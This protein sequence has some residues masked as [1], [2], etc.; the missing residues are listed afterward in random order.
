MGAMG[1]S[2]KRADGVPV[3]A[4]S[5]LDLDGGLGSLLAASV[6]SRLCV[7]GTGA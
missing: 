4:M 6:L 5:D 7:A 3:G 2:M 1:G